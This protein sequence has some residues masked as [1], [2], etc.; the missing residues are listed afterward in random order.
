M[1]NLESNEKINVILKK[2]ELIESKL[3]NLIEQNKKISKE[4]QRMD[5][6]V[7]FVEGVYDTVK[8][9]FHFMMNRINKISYLTNSNNNVTPT[10][11]LITSSTKM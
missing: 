5:S 1:S 7:T 9:P 6:H 8:S 3:D 11:L 2:L 4:T 10:N